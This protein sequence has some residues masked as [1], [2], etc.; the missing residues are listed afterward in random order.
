MLGHLGQVEGA[1]RDLDRAGP[2]Q[3]AGQRVAQR[4]VVRA[5]PLQRRGGPVGGGDEVAPDRLGQGADQ[6]G[7]QLL[8]QPRDLPV[9]A[10]RVDLVEHGQGDVDGDA[11]GVAARLELVGQPQAVP[12]LDPGV[13]VV[14]GVGRAG[15]VLDQHRALEVEQV[16]PLLAGPLP[17]GVEVAGRDD[18]VR[19]ALV[20]EVEQGVVVDQDV[21]AAGPVLQLLDLGQEPPV[22]GEELVR[23]LPVALDQGVADEQLAGHLGV[24]RPVVD[25]PL[26]HDRHPVEG[27]P[28]RGHHRPARPRPVRLGVGPLDQVGGQRLDPLG[29]DGGRLPP[30]QARGLD[31]LGR[32]HPLGRLPGQRRPGE[33]GEPGAAR[34]QVLAGVALLEADVA[35]Q[36][37]QQGGVDAVGVGVGLGPVEL[38]AEVAG[39]GAELAVEVLPLAD[40][41]VVEELGPAQLAELVRGQLGLAFVQVAPEVQPGQEVGALVG[42]A[43]VLL[44]GRL[45]TVGRALARV[46]DGQGGH[47]HQHLAGAA[48]PASLQQ[49]PGQPGSAGTWASRRPTLVS[50]PPPSRAP[51][52]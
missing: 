18:L 13:G 50:R 36:P 48:E 33:D 38:D 52:S 35:E 14:D 7:D 32:H 15:G 22:A 8:A 23:G 41:Q 47:D 16:G 37:G 30:P 49:H 25:L 27:H 12:A 29:P 4:P 20:V 6:L 2:L 11:V 39:D 40:P 17:P 5:D 3:L 9:E 24:D 46:L 51:S 43:A 1:G 21:A 34:A 19:D 45:L 42:E 10:V 44:V 28:L 31:Q 26:G